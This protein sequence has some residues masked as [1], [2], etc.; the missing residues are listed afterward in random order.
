MKGRRQPLRKRK[1]SIDQEPGE[2]ASKS[3]TR[4]PNSDSTSNRKREKTDID[5]W[6]K[7]EK[8]QETQGDSEESEDDEGGEDISL[9]GNVM[10]EEEFTFVFNDMKEDYTEGICVILKTLFPNPTDA[11]SVACSVTAQSNFVLKLVF[12][13]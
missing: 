9:I 6:E 13:W 12:Y 7:I 8:E 11:Y 5:E 3:C 4:N 1:A 2:K 10:D